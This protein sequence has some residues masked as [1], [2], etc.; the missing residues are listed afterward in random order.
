MKSK[1]VIVLQQVRRYRAFK[2]NI[3]ENCELRLLLSDQKKR[4]RVDYEIFSY[5]HEK[6]FFTGYSCAAI[7]KFFHNYHYFSG[8]I[9]ET[10]I[11]SA[12]QLSAITCMNW[13]S[14]ILQYKEPECFSNKM[15]R[16]PHSNVLWRYNGET[17]RELPGGLGVR[18][19]IQKACTL[20]MISMTKEC[21]DCPIKSKFGAV[22]NRMPIS[23]VC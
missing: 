5:R 3:D 10:R 12:A 20:K 4:Q 15:E 16:V 22:S 2:K 13:V 17:P 7:S 1:R 9:L 6:N 8:Q 11:Q 18:A 23:S 19:E 14:K 21:E